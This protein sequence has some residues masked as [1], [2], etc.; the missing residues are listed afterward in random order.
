MVEIA[1]PSALQKAISIAGSEAKLAEKVGFSQPAINKAKRKGHCS[2]EMAVAI[3]SALA[4]D[5]TKSDLRPDLWPA[6]VSA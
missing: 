3:D 1:E 4:P 2:A 5:V 6:A